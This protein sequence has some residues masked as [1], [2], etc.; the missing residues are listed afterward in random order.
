MQ[1]LQKKQAPAAAK[2]AAKA[3]DAE[4][5]VAMEEKQPLVNGTDPRAVSRN[6][7]A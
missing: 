4:K 1:G 6:V 2:P 5:A 3:V 7:A